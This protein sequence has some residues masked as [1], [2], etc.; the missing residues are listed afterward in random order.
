MGVDD[1][2]VECVDLDFDPKFV[3]FS[4]FHFHIRVKGL[5]DV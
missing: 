1:E 4:L 5:G 3:R 2:S